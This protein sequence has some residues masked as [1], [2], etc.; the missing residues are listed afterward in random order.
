MAGRSDGGG[1]EPNQTMTKMVDWALTL[2]LDPEDE[3]IVNRAFNT[4]SPNECS[5]NQCLSYIRKSAIFT[6]L[7]IKKQAGS[8]PELQLA[9][10]ESA[11]LKKKRWHGWDMSLPLP[12]IYVE[13]HV[14]HWC[15]FVALRDGLVKT[16]L[17]SAE[18]S[19]LLTD[20]EGYAWSFHH[21]SNRFDRRN[22][23]NP[24]PA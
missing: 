11:A 4:L 2:E 21:G 1:E 6:N 12:G 17:P 9:L 22:M 14:W 3:D 13:G 10:W 20:S 7:E 16:P 19:T 8:D 23:A 18:N 24:L 15:L 5:L